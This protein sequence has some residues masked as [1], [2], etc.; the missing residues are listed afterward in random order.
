MEDLGA[1]Y[2]VLLHDPDLRHRLTGAAESIRPSF[3]EARISLGPRNGNAPEP[4]EMSQVPTVRSFARRQSE[5]LVP[6]GTK[7]G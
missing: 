7:Q 6:R 4:P 5:A 3:V 2:G 1:S